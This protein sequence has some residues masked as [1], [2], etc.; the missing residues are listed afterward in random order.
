MK[1]VKVAFI[2]NGKIDWD[3]VEDGVLIGDKVLTEGGGDY[4][5][6][7]FVGVDKDGT[8]LVEGFSTD[9]LAGNGL[10]LFDLIVEHSNANFHW[11]SNDPSGGTR[12][13]NLYGGGLQ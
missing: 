13:S 10:L 8:Y 3:W 6:H 1:R 12:P 7:K 5:L 9:Y 11:I 2:Y 4:S